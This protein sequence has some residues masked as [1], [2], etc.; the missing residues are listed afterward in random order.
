M[1]V[2]SSVRVRTL[3]AQMAR[4]SSVRYSERTRADIHDGPKH[5]TLQSEAGYI[6]ARPPPPIRRNLLATHGRTIHRVICDQNRALRSLPLLPQER[7]YSG[8]RWWSGSCRKC[9]AYSITLSARARRVAGIS[10][11]SALAVLRLIVR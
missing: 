9:A 3:V 11:P 10:R 8:H 2:R 7:K 6:D 1:E 5:N 4:S